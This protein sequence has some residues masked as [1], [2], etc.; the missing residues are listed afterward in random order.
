[1]RVRPPSAPEQVCVSETRLLLH[2]LLSPF[3][4]SVIS[5][6]NGCVFWPRRRCGAFPEPASQLGISAGFAAK[7]E[8]Q[9]EGRRREDTQ[10]RE[11]I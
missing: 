6:I 10:R 9:N 7:D 2:L 5:R 3:H 8:D 11:N 1:M 4:F